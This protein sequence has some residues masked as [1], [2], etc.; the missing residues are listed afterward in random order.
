MGS[1]CAKLH[2]AATQHSS[3]TSPP[4]AG[5]T[6]VFLQALCSAAARGHPCARAVLGSRFAVGLKW[7]L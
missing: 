3:P 5:T 4:L 1:H 7:S 2:S 6:T